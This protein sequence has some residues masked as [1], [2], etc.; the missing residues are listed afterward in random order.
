MRHCT[1]IS[2]KGGRSLTGGCTNA[3]SEFEGLV[4]VRSILGR[5]SICVMLAAV[6]ISYPNVSTVHAQNAD[7]AGFVSPDDEPEIP[8]AGN[9]NS[10]ISLGIRDVFLFRDTNGKPTAK[11]GYFEPTDRNQHFQVTLNQALTDAAVG[12]RFI[13][14][15]TSVGRN[16]IVFQSEKL[17]TGN[18]LFTMLTNTSDWPVG[19]YRGEVYA[20]G[21]LVKTFNY[22]IQSSVLRNEPIEVGDILI[23]NEQR[24]TPLTSV[25]PSYQRLFFAA[26]ITGARSTPMRVR[27]MLTAVNTDGGNGVLLDQ[28][29]PNVYIE[30]SEI[31]AFAELPRDWPKGTYR[32]DLWLDGRAAKTMEYV[33]Q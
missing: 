11:V 32:M 29:L 17:V 3:G 19:D 30:G 26:R 7:N 23:Y 28:D 33:I 13:A 14:V 31:S 5:L 22:R 1:F 6:G 16:Q 15:N 24:S 25:L 12:W 8:T 20:G 27:W 4:H 21:K 9:G 18:I 10:G 2:M